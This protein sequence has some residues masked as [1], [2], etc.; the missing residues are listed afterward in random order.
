MQGFCGILAL[1]NYSIDK[2]A[3]ERSIN[4]DILEDI[5]TIAIKEEIKEKGAVRLQ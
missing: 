1:E 4:L 2:V 3:F 5:D